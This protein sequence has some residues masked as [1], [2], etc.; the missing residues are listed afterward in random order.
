M[1]FG[2]TR[3]SSFNVLRVQRIGAVTATC[4]GLALPPKPGTTTQSVDD[5]SDRRYP[6]TEAAKN[7]TSSASSHPLPSASHVGPPSLE[8]NQGL[9][10]QAELTRLGSRS[11]SCPDGNHDINR[12]GSSIPENFV[13]D[14]Q[15]SSDRPGRVGPS[16]G[17]VQGSPIYP[18]SARSTDSRSIPLD[19]SQH[20][21]N[22]GV[23]LTCRSSPSSSNRDLVPANVPCDAPS[24][25]FISTTRPTPVRTGG[26]SYAQRTSNYPPVPQRPISVPTG[27]TVSTRADLGQ[28]ISGWERSRPYAMC[29]NLPSQARRSTSPP[30]HDRT[31]TPSQH[32]SRTLPP[33]RAL[34]RRPS[35]ES[36]RDR[37]IRDGTVHPLPPSHHLPESS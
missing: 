1:F 24:S 4:T 19:A 20:R 9:V 34:R 5:L 13:G 21:S 30:V 11:I 26:M 6:S 25:L 33:G 17:A 16:P 28:E 31:V 37:Y 27:P 18:N 10:R 32:A 3:E 8:N 12:P 15:P 35:C 29:N 36:L 7:G 22:T 2:R 14:V 23:A